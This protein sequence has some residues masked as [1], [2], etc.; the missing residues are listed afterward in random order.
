MYTVSFFVFNDDNLLSGA[1]E[2]ETANASA[3]A[4]ACRA[5]RI[6]GGVFTYTALGLEVC[7]LLG[8]IGVSLKFVRYTNEVSR[9]RCYNYDC[10]SKMC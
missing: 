10:R 7:V 6:N 5:D 4:L 8:A 9:Q 1:R 2:D 3:A